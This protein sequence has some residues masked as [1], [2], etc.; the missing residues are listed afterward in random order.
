MSGDDVLLARRQV[1]L[2]GI[3]IDDSTANVVVMKLLYLQN[4]DRHA[5]ITLHIESPGGS[6]S[7]GLAIIDTIDQITPPVRTCC[8]GHVG[9]IATLIAAHGAKAERFAERGSRLSL[10]EPYVSGNAVAKPGELEKTN[11][12]LAE[13][14]ANDTGR[15]LED[16]ARAM[17]C[18]LCLSATQ[19]KEFGLIDAIGQCPIALSE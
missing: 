19:A 4:Q 10:S 16:A 1:I 12:I 5:P 3:I 9:S 18:E 8:H 17:T 11:R 14:L 6:V 15:T 13:F 2:H 7:A